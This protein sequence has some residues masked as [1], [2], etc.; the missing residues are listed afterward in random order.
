MKEL[1]QNVHAED[2]ARMKSDIEAALQ[3]GA[4]PYRSEYRVAM[5]DGRSAWISD[6][7]VVDRA[8]D[9]RPRRLIGT[10]MN[11]TDRKAAEIAHQESLQRISA[12]FRLAPVAMAIATMDEGRQ[13]E[14]NEARLK[15]TGH[16]EDEMIG[17]TP[18]E[19]GFYFHPRD[20]LRLRREM[21]LHGEVSSQEFELRRKNGEVFTGLISAG[22][23]PLNGK[24]HLLAT[25]VDITERK[26]AESHTQL[27][28]REVNHRSKNLLAVTQAVARQTASRSSPSEFVSRFTARIQALAAS[29]DLVVGSEWRGVDTGDLVY[30]QLAH[31]ESW[32]GTRIRMEGQSLKITA[33]TAQGIGMALHELATNAAKY[34]ALSGPDGCVEVGWGIET[35][36]EEQAFV[37]WWRES[38]GP[39]V[40]PP[41]RRGFGQTVIV[42]LA[43][44]AVKGRARLQ[45][46]ETGVVWELRGP[47]ET[48]CEGRPVAA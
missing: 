18:E 40:V 4:G 2:R 11:V 6:F 43:Q 39:K 46:P 1:L 22:P 5:V 19:I 21:R 48:I 33:T 26:R 37:I 27:L 7:G 8:A 35:T 10:A 24:P 14:V 32:M 3:P 34:G 31:L 17:R 29:H 15:L 16:T 28:L 13:V 45:F 12:A 23:I 36:C 25:I 44:A 42:D 38:G 30:A 20:F 9:G 47:V 41:S